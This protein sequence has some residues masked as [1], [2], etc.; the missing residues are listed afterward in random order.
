M[1]WHGHGDITTE[2]KDGEPVI[3]VCW[4]CGGHENRKKI[5]RLAFCMLCNSYYV[6]GLMLSTLENEKEFDKAMTDLGLKP[7]QSTQTLTL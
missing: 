3:R 2:A 1:I 5:N 6:A 7:G 4:E